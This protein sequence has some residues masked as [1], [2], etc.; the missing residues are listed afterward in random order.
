LNHVNFT[1]DINPGNGPAVSPVDSGNRFGTRVFW[2]AVIANGD[3]QVNPLTGAAHL[4]VHNLP[5]LDYYA[6]DGQGDLASLG[7]TWQTGYFASTVSIDVV[8]SGP[9]TRRVNVHDAANGFAGLFNE[10]QATVTWSASSTSGFSF[11]SNPGN[12]ATSVPE[13]P[14]VNGV[15]APLNFFAQVG[16]ERNGIFFPAGN[17]G[18]APTGAVLTLAL[19]PPAA[20]PV[21]GAPVIAHRLTA[22]IQHLSNQTDR[23]HPGQAAAASDHLLAR[24]VPPQLLAEVFADL[25][26]SL[27]SDDF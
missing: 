17:G 25:D 11:T 24:A 5:E 10:N 20:A 18:A 8:W 4:H 2:T 12:F 3:V 23:D 9:V 26:S 14:G 15:T 1:H 13:V 6:P 7:P 21:P 22:A 27:L 19:P 16:F